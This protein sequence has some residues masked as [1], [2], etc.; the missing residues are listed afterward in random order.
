MISACNPWNTA[1]ILVIETGKYHCSY[2][3]KEVQEW[4]EYDHHEKYTYRN[5]DCDSANEQYRI[6]SYR[7][8][9]MP[10]IDHHF[11]AEVNYKNE[12]FKINK[13]FGK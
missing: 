12:I 6:E 3:T 7:A 5:C 9:R 1:C 10:E 11:L 13:R 8:P 4:D 2:C